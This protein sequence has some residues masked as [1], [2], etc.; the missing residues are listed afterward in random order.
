MTTLYQY[1]DAL[2]T[3]FSNWVFIYEDEDPYVYGYPLYLGH[4]LLSL[5][6]RLGYVTNS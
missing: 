2:S 1:E 4:L 6:S 5:A 3:S